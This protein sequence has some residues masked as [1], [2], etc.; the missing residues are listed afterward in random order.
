MIV[1]IAYSSLLRL[2]VPLSSFLFVSLFILS[3]MVV[4]NR[5]SLGTTY[6]DESIVYVKT[7][8]HT[9]RVSV[10]SLLSVYTLLKEK[11]LSNFFFIFFPLEKNNVN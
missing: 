4:I 9:F 7:F 6:L 3:R 1:R 11:G 8:T 10:I 5:W 2:F